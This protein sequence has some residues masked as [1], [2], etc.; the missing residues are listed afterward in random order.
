MFAVFACTVSSCSSDEDD[1]VAPPATGDTGDVS[2]TI[3]TGGSGGNGSSSSPIVVDKGKTL[4]MVLSQKSSYTDPD[5]SVITREPKANISLKAKLDTLYAKDIKTLTSVNDNPKVESSSS[6]TAPLRNQIVQTFSIGGQEI[7]FDLAYEI[8][9][10]VNSANK[11]IEM[12]YIKLNPAQYG[13]ASSVEKKDDQTRAQASV[14]G[15]TLTPLNQTRSVTVTDST[16]Y[17]VSVSFNL[18][19]ESVNTKDENKQNLSFTVNYI[20]IVETSTEYPDPE[21]QFSYDFNILGGTKDKASPFTLTKGETLYLEWK[22]AIKHTYFSLPELAMKTLNFEPSAYIK[23]SAASDTL[24]AET[25]ADFEKVNTGEPV[26]SITSEGTEQNASSQVFDIG[27]QKV[28]AEWVYEIC[29]GKMPDGEEITLPYLELGNLKLVSVSAVKKGG[30]DDVEDIGDKQAEIYEITAKFSQDLTSQKSNDEVKQT[31]EY[32]VKYI[33]AVEVKLATVKYRKDYIW[34]EPHDNIPLALQFILYRDRTYSNG[35]TFTDTYQ[36]NLMDVDWQIS[37]ATPTQDENFLID[38]E[39]TLTN[40]DKVFY[41]KTHFKHTEYGGVFY[42]KTRVPNISKF[43]PKVLRDE[44]PM[45]KPGENLEEYY[46]FG[47]S[48]YFDPAVPQQ[49]WYSKMIERYKAIDLKPIDGIN[50][51]RRYRL[52]FAFPDR[53]CYVKDNI[54]EKLVDF[55]DDYL[56]TF[57]FDYREEQTTTPESY[58]ARVVTFDCKGHYLGQE[59]YIAVIDTIYQVTPLQ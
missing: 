58:P 20:G 31:L 33:G 19:L 23:L 2:V 35:V 25:A 11:T 47:E 37:P 57:D 12:P 55:R 30:A 10:I 32:I 39:A 41:H 16:A 44:Y 5:G 59:F 7:T 21:T 8:Y 36:S 15:I 9:K 54:D 13:T 43:E 48:R 52:S 34:H 49:G 46:C 42:C 14:T 4:N 1:P 56:M 51:L 3:D 22:Q 24:W 53:F 29:R 6:G 26:V 18:D 40:G 38:Q 27:G 45:G 17:N 28:S 50:F